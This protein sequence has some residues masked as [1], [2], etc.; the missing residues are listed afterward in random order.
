[1]R[2]R[3]ISF[4][5]AVAILVSALSGCAQSSSGS[6]EG[7]VQLY[8]LNSDGDGL[9][10][11]SYVPKTQGTEKQIAEFINEMSEVPEGADYSPLIESGIGILGRSL[12]D[13][14][15]TLD[16]SAAYKSMSATREV[17]TR[18]G[19]VRSLIQIDGISKVSFEIDGKPATT[20]DGTEIGIM[21]SDTFVE[22]AARQINTIQHTTIDLYYTDE[23]GT[24]LSMESR[25]I[26]YSASKP[27][28]WAI[29][30]RL[31]AGPA[32]EGNYP[33]LPSNTQIISVTSNGGI[34]YVN[35]GQTFITDALL[36]N[37]EIPIYSIV[38]TICKNCDN[39]SRVQLS[40]EGESSMKFRDAVDLSKP[41]GPDYSLVKRA[42]SDSSQ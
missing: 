13:G 20:P 39:V 28:E 3:I 18:A 1:M 40:I 11:R 23:T 37:A 32:V 12:D 41:L 42:E 17:L 8:Y 36:V 6:E 10:A 21:D 24:Q 14:I 33:T 25:S 19:I 22:N 2:R 35:L 30:E 15:L 5:A 34:C 7:A 9:Y 31:I 29:V 38:D 4:L 27:L 16:F 26:Y